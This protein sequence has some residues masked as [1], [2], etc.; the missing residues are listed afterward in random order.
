MSVPGPI[1]NTKKRTTCIVMGLVIVLLFSLALSSRYQV[2]ADRPAKSDIII[3]FAGPDWDSRLLKARQLLHEGYS[4]YLFI[5]VTFSLYKAGPGR[6]GITAI[7]FTDIKPGIDLSG[8]RPEKEMIN[9]FF[10]KNW[11]AYRFPRYYEA[12]NVE[13]LLAKKSMDAC[14]LKK[15]I[16]VSSPY[17]MRRI[18]I[19]A[20]RI[21]DPSYDIKLVPSHI[22][23]L[24]RGLPASWGK[25][26]QAF[27]ECA[28]TIW[29]LCY[30]LWDQ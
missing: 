12:T 1:R 14:G 20:D 7:R 27:T 8:S 30:E 26:K 10:R 17:H 13:M 11:T 22:G 28:K 29:F 16:F 9:V 2:Y 23:T 6:G 3:L 18:K 4:G 25:L 5:P 15:A 24:N 19:M 21:F